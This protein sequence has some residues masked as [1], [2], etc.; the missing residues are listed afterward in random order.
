MVQYP[1]SVPCSTVFSTKTETNDHEVSSTLNL[2]ESY[3]ESSEHLD[4]D[5]GSHD[6]SLNQTEDYHPEEAVNSTEADNAVF[7]LP[8]PKK[9]RFPAVPNS[10]AIQCKWDGCGECF[11][12]HGNLSDHIKVISPSIYNLIHFIAVTLGPKSKVLIQLA[13]LQLAIWK[14]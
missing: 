8:N 2:I 9:I 7:A 10:S 12:T 3:S 6:A 14:F 11:K 13:V 1:T 4:H 5:E